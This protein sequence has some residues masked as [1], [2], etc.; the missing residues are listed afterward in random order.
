MDKTRKLFRVHTGFGDCY[1]VAGDYTEASDMV[2][3]RLNDADYGPYDN[4]VVTKVELIAEEYFFAGKQQFSGFR[5][6]VNPL[7]VCG[8]M[9]SPDDDEQAE[10]K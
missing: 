4:R 7:M 9:E 8:S 5:K 6:E 10:G 1:V 2:E 3:K